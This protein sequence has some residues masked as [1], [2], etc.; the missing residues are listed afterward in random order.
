MG[1]DHKREIWVAQEEKENPVSSTYLELKYLNS[2]CSN[3]FK[4]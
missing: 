1:T 4:R 2:T 3:R